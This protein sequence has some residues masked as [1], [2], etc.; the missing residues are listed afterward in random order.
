MLKTYLKIAYR[1]LSHNKT[2]G[3][4]NVMGLA[5]SITCGILIF[6]LVKYHLSLDNFHKE[7]DRI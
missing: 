4:L 2:Y 5:L 6:T 1:N 7:P 3:F